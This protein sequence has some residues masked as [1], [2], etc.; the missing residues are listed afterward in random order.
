MKDHGGPPCNSSAQ[1]SQWHNTAMERQPLAIGYDGTRRSQHIS[2]IRS[3][4][5]LAQHAHPVASQPP[6][7]VIF[8]AVRSAAFDRLAMKVL[9]LGAL[10]EM[11]TPTPPTQH[12]EATGRTRDF[13][14]PGLCAVKTSNEVLLECQRTDLDLKVWLSHM[15][16]G[17]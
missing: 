14:W 9:E 4:L 12:H 17:R 1:L 13:Q 3:F 6:S 8:L 10:P 2:R 11:H 15:I 5:V 16:C 7:T